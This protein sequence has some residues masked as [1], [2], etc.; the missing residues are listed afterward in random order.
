LQ[1]NDII[2]AAAFTDVM[3]N[4]VEI[5]GYQL[6]MSSHDRAEAEFLLRKFDAAGLPCTVVSL[7]APAREGVRWEAPQ[8]N[9]PVSHATQAAIA[10]VS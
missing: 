7:T 3:R 10:N 6:L 1:R 8:Y 4:L 9:G 5:E 2:H